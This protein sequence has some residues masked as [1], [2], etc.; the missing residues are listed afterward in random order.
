MKP[1][2]LVIQ[3]AKPTLTIKK[4]EGQHKL[5]IAKA[6]TFGN[7]AAGKRLDAVENKNTEQDGRLDAVEAR[8]DVSVRFYQGDAPADVEPLAVGG[9][10]SDTLIN[11][12]TRLRFGS[13][14]SIFNNYGSIEDDEFVYSEIVYLIK[15]VAY[16]SGKRL[17][18]VIGRSDR[19]V[20]DRKDLAD[21]CIAL[22]DEVYMMIDAT[23]FEFRHSQDD[24]LLIFTIE[25]NPF[26]GKDQVRVRVE[27]LLWTSEIPNSRPGKKLFQAIKSSS[28]WQVL[29][30]LKPQNGDIDKAISDL[31]TKDM[32]LDKDIADLKKA[33]SEQDDKIDDLETITE[34]LEDREE[35]A[36]RFYQ[37]DAPADVEPLA[38]GATLLDTTLTAGVSGNDVGFNSMT[39]EITNNE[40]TYKNIEYQIEGI[41]FQSGRASRLS[42]NIQRKDRMAIQK[43]VVENLCL[44]LD[45]NI[46]MVA[47]AVRKIYS[48]STLRFYTG[49]VNNPFIKSTV[50]LRV[51]PLLWEIKVPAY[52]AT[53]N[54]YIAIKTHAGW[55]VV[56]V[57]HPFDG[58]S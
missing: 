12:G 13:G 40:F 10:L 47:D 50:R 3:Q 43:S 42:V 15:V 27:P 9:A 26:E 11:V 1:F 21:L 49:M 46:F 33:I 38:A 56:A 16:V 8:K 18:F 17:G 34:A 7:L 25:S 20:I 4:E 55:Q 51:E 44:A 39:G 35:V 30:V 19:K 6:V 14:F 2:T 37:G 29:R 52:E 36:V 45:V 31:K 48:G 5:E 58:G 32:A 23:S 54:L 41:I 24:A 57:D 22:D 53:K 28:G